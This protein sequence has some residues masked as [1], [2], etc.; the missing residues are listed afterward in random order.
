T[1]PFEPK[2]RQGFSRLAVERDETAIKSAKE[3]T[4]TAW[5]TGLHFQVLPGRNP[6]GSHFRE[7]VCEVYLRVVL[8]K[9]G[10]G[11]RIKGN[12]IVVRSAKEQPV[13][14]QDGSGLEGG[15]AHQL[16]L[17]LHCAG[18]IRPG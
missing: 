6:S 9:P 3:D 15:F 5:L 2:P 17:L 8:P 10:T 1:S 4:K 7:I 18:A 14:D 16:S 13:L 12:D 11:F